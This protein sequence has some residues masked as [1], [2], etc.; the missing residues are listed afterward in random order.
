MFTLEVIVIEAAAATTAVTE[1][2][3]SIVEASVV[4]VVVIY[5]I[6]NWPFKLNKYEKFEK[7]VEATSEISTTASLLLVS[8]LAL[9]ILGQ[10]FLSMHICTVYAVMFLD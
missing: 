5:I 8:A 3:A 1:V 10:G 2:I 6:N 7:S 9:L 4:K